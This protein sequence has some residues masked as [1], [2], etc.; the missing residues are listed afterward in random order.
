MVCVPKMLHYPSP[1]LH[2]TAFPRHLNAFPSC[3]NLK[4][5]ILEAILLQG[6][7]DMTHPAEALKSLAVIKST[8]FML[9]V[10]TLVS[11]TDGYALEVI[12]IDCRLRLC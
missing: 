2:I 9:K 10:G 6:L 8:S 4:E 12:S 3:Y 1:F 7:Q 5:C 11:Q